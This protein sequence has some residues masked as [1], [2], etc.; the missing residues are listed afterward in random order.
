[1]AKEKAITATELKKALKVLTHKDITELV[2]EIAAAC[3]LARDFLTAK[4]STDENRESLLQKYKQRIESGFYTRSG[5]PQLSL[6]VAKQAIS[7]FKK[8]NKDKAMLVDLM[9]F[10]VEN[11]VDFTKQFGDIDEGFYNSAIGVYAQV[12]KE[13]NQDENIYNEFAGRIEK[14]AENACDG[15]CFKDNMLD[16]YYEIAWLPDEEELDT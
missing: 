6:R 12:V 13:I 10:Y 5:N 9:L 2:C 14:A 3:P 11:C 7:D 4:F 1:M 8:T 15:W 16:L